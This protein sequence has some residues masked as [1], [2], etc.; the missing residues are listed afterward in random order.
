MVPAA[1]IAAM[2]A[3]LLLCIA[4]PT[5]SIAALSRRHSNVMRAFAVGAVAFFVSQII[6]RIPLMVLATAV[7]PDTIGAFVSSVP[8]ASFSAGL[9]EETAR[10]LFMMWLLKG[11]LRRADGIA[12]GLGHGGIEA[13]L[14]VGMTMLN[15]LILA[16]MIN[17]RVFD[18]F[19]NLLP[20]E[21]AAELQAV[22]INTPSSQFLAGG[23]ERIWAIGL[24]VTCSLIILMGIARTQRILA[25]CT[26]VL[27][28]GF[29]NLAA[30][31]AMQ[32]GINTW[33]VEVG[34]L[35]VI[36]GLLAF[37]LW[38]AGKWLEAKPQASPVG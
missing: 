31:G 23:V 33:L 10:L 35:F 9:F 29:T 8:V 38:L 25:W 6:L 18:L 4:L 7:S 24:H 15:N 30:I 22:L 13:I 36:A 34:G 16:L 32:H 28:H 20:P 17:F 19:G 26:A 12:F 3:T 5:L 2:V 11:Y 1:S 14:L 27:V 21:A 37:V